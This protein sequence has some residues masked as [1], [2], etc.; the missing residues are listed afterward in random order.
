MVNDKAAES[1]NLSANFWSQ[2]E[3]MRITNDPIN[4]PNV[5]NAVEIEL[6]PHAPHIKFVDVNDANKFTVV[7]FIDMA[8][9]INPRIRNYQNH[10]NPSQA[11]LKA[12]RKAWKSEEVW[13][14][15]EEGWATKIGPCGFLYVFSEGGLW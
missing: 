4:H 8:A 3:I 11:L 2:D 9:K 5:P 10:K 1:T 7:I 12:V 14:S 13:L 15:Q 6:K